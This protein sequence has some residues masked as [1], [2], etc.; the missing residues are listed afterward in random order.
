[1]FICGFKPDRCTE[2]AALQRQTSD[3]CRRALGAEHPD[4]LDSA[5][6]LSGT[7]YAQWYQIDPGA[8]ANKLGLT[9]SNCGTLILGN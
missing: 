3:V 8:Y 6:N 4:T 1:M 7:L 2:A 5:N 9:T